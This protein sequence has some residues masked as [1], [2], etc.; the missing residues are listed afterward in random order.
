MQSELRKQ[1]GVGLYTA[2]RM[3]RAI[4]LLTIAELREQPG[5]VWPDPITGRLAPH[6]LHRA[7]RSLR[8]VAR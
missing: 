1:P 2:H 8:C 4:P 5:D 7:I 6:R 3:A